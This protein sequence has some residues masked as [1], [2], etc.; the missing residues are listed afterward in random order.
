MLA[1]LLVL[2]FDVFIVIGAFLPSVSFRVTDSERMSQGVS[3]L[4]V[5]GLCSYESNSGVDRKRDLRITK[6]VHFPSTNSRSSHWHR[7][8]VV[9]FKFVPLVVMVLCL[10]PAYR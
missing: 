1:M 6:L 7:T 5:W 4:P 2:V 10:R 8:A 3:R 9:I